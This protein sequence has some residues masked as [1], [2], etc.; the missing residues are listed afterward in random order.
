VTLT[1]DVTF[2][3]SNL[4]DAGNDQVRYCVVRII[5][6]TVSRNF[7]LP[8][9]TFIGTAAPSSIA[10]NKKGILEIWSY[11]NVDTSCFARWTVTP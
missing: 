7:T 3:T 8:S 5:G 1:G 6:D 10:G 11:S 4:N 2:T 9:W